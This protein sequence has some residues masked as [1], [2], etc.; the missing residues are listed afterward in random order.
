MSGAL[1]PVQ[2][3]SNAA[4]SRTIQGNVPFSAMVLFLAAFVAFTYYRR[5][6]WFMLPMALLEAFSR[7]YLGVHYPSDVLTGVV[8]ALLG[9]GLPPFDAARLGACLHGLE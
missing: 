5:S 4:L 6:A 9:Q 2:A 3:A 1:I 7:V 8:A